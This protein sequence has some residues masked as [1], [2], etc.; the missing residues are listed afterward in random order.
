[1]I[2]RESAERVGPVWVDTRVVQSVS[3]LVHEGLIVVQP[4]LRTS[5]QMHDARRLGARSRGRGETSAACRRGPGGCCCPRQGRS[6]APT[7]SPGR[8]RLPAPSCT[9]SRVIPVAGH[10]PCVLTTVSPRGPGRAAAGLQ[11][12]RIAMKLPSI[13]SLVA[14]STDLR[15]RSDLLFLLAPRDRVGLFG[16]VRLEFLIGA[17][18][19][20]PLLVEVVQASWL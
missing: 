8:P 5:D 9:S 11:R 20:E 2:A 7:A 19:L 1:M 3:G 13:A 18:Q 10:T 17:Q 4:A 16:Q 12:S 15:W 6:R 14:A